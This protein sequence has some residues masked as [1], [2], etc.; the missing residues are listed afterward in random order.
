MNT[1]LLTAFGLL[2]AAP[3]MAQ[4]APATAPLTVT[5]DAIMSGKPID[6]KYAYC[7]PDGKGKTENGGNMNP[8]LR[9]S[10][11]PAGTKSYAVIVVDPDVPASFE[12]ANQEGKTIPENFGRR[13]FYHWVLVDVPP[14]VT[15]IPEG[16]ASSGVTASGKPVGET[17][18]GITG[19]NDYSATSGSYDGPC[20]PWNDE[21][22]HHYHFRV[23]ALDVPTLNLPKGFGGKEVSAA[24]QGHVLA[25]GELVGTYTNRQR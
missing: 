5:S 13:D 6:A 16:K 17:E 7:K 11:A 23:Y 24:M 8:G 21:R 20:P 3:A 19:H 25:Q 14:S 4:T 12:L 18:F 2:V 22:L 9:W 15:E 10:G 1:L